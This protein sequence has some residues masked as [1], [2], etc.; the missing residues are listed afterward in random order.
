AAA[1]SLR[2][3]RRVGRLEIGVAGLTLVA[4]AIL[5]S[6]V[7]PALVEVAARQPAPPRLVA[8]GAAGAMKGTLEG[9]PG[10]PGQNGFTLRVY[11]RQTTKTV[12]GE[13]ALRFEMPARPDLEAS[14]LDLTRAADG[15]YAGLGSN[16]TLIGDWRIT[17]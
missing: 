8:Q 12:A 3:L 17:A 10:Y 1:R 5:T 7:P 16:L 6:L 11:D 15:S 4:S 9:S 14:T 13:A 2:G